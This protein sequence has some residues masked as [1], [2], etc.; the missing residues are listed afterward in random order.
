MGAG[1]GAAM[2]AMGGMG[3]ASGG[4]AAAG[5]GLSSLGGSLGGVA[6][7]KKQDPASPPLQMGIV[8]N[9]QPTSP[10]TFDSGPTG[11]V[12]PRVEGLMR[13]QPS[14]PKPS[15]MDIMGRS[16]WR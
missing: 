1:G 2:G 9:P 10:G 8:Q 13:M 14:R 11:D 3:G 16:D 5:A 15:Y 12:D 4:M 6:D 7:K